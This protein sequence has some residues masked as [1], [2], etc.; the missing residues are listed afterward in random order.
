[1]N[2]LRR[3]AAAAVLLALAASAACSGA[4]A[5][6]PGVSACPADSGRALRPQGDGWYHGPVVEVDS[7]RA[8]AGPARERHLRLLVQVQPSGAWSG[9]IWFGV[10]DSTVLLCRSGERLSRSAP[11]SAGTTVS[12]KA[13]M[14][15]ESDPG[16]A[17]ADTLIVDPGP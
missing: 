17:F 10:N 2:A 12:A 14:I 4:T 9:R 5:S 6:G 15:M 3:C 11:L 13:P 16:Q 1:M 8:E 7:S